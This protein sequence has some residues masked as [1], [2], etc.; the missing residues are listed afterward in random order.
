MCLAFSHLCCSLP[1]PACAR[2]CLDSLVACAP[3]TQG[4][5]NIH[6][7]SALLLALW[8]C[9]ATAV[10]S[11]AANGC[12]RHAYNAVAICSRRQYQCH[13]YAAARRC[14][15]LRRLGC[16]CCPI[17]RPSNLGCWRSSPTVFFSVCLVPV[18]VRVEDRLALGAQVLGSG[19]PRVRQ[20]RFRWSSADRSRASSSFAWRIDWSARC[21]QTHARARVRN[22]S[23]S[24][25]APLRADREVH[26]LA[27]PQSEAAWWAWRRES[28]ASSQ[29]RRPSSRGPGGGGRGAS[30]VRGSPT[31]PRVGTLIG[32]RIVLWQRTRGAA[33]RRA[34][35]VEVARAR[36]TS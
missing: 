12:R 16:V 4:N 28:C 24:P 32:A 19:T 15:A 2:L 9:A 7:R 14:A 35:C 34:A 10:M 6:N 25:V 13:M 5:M 20:Q 8:C 27:G 33:A 17:T 11:A 23:A 21:S 29:R 30:R 36:S 26:Q 31:R 1:T 22:S 3:G 18:A